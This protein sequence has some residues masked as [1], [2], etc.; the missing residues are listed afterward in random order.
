VEVVVVQE[1]SSSGRRQFVLAV[2]DVVVF[3]ATAKPKTSA[4]DKHMYQRRY[5]S[6]RSPKPILH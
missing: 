5:E 6:R 2:S 1:V 3:D 4:S